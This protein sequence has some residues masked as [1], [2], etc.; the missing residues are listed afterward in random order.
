MTWI[1]HGIKM[2]WKDILK[3]LS[4]RERMD[5]EDFAPEEMGEWREEQANDKNRYLL[6]K[7]AER[8]DRLEMYIN[9][10]DM[11]EHMSEI[12]PFFLKRGR[13]FLKRKEGENAQRQWRSVIESLRG[14]ENSPFK[15]GNPSPYRKFGTKGREVDYD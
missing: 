8:F 1:G 14:E 3:E 7:Y 12:L 13:M 4:P 10:G 11:S 9:S 6:E 15:R 2:S 5:A